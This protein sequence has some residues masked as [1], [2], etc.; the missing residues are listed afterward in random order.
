MVFTGHRA[1]PSPDEVFKYEEH[2]LSNHIT[3]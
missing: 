3:V 1:N 2:V